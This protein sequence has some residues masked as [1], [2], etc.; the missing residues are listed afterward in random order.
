VRRIPKVYGSLLALLLAGAP[1]AGVTLH[2]PVLATFEQARCWGP[3]PRFQVTV[4]ADGVVEWEGRENVRVAGRRTSRLNPTLLAGLRSA[5]AQAKYLDLAGDFACA[6]STERL[7]I[8]TTYTV[9]G[10]TKSID[11]ARGCTE[12]AGVAQLT[13]LENQFEVIVNTEQWIGAADR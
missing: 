6:G 9:D 12:T 1:D 10:H 13:K 5:F 3:C 8:R 11:H 2:A 7:F 4:Y